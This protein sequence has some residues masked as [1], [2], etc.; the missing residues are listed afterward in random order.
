M[1]LRFNGKDEKTFTLKENSNG[2]SFLISDGYYTYLVSR[3]KSSKKDEKEA[4]PDEMKIVVETYDFSTSENTSI[5]STELSS[6]VT[7]STNPL[8]KEPVKGRISLSS[9]KI[10]NHHFFLHSGKKPP[11]TQLDTNYAYLFLEIL[12]MRS[13]KFE[14][15]L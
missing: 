10:Q 4:D 13:R 11:S 14:C 2:K 12:L 1:E 3:R 6:V 8:S 15:F 9:I 7:P 5:S